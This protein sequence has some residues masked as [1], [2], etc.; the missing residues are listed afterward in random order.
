MAFSL[1]SD[2]ATSKGEDGAALVEAIKTGY[3]SLEEALAVHG[4]LDA[5]FITYSELTDDDKRSLTDLLNA[6]AEPLSQLTVTVLE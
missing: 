4:S 3:G 5:G 1:V 6:L 2:F